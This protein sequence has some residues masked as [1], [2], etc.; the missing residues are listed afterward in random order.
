[1]TTVVEAEK[2]HPDKV[3]KFII[4]AYFSV[5]PAL[6]EVITLAEQKNHVKH[7]LASG[8]TQLL[9]LLIVIVDTEAE[10]MP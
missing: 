10:D 3:P 6:Y 9:M 7:L 2:Y 5:F 8:G 1:M 4:D